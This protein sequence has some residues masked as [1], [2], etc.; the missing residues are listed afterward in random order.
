MVIN[1]NSKEGIATLVKSN[2]PTRVFFDRYKTIEDMIMNFIVQ[3]TNSTFF[4]LK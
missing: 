4:Q 1:G 3:K 2:L